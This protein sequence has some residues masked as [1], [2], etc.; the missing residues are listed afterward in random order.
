MSLGDLLVTGAMWSL[1]LA[2]AWATLICAAAAVEVVSSGRLA[3]TAWLGCPAPARR[4]LLAGLGVVLASGGAVGTSPVSAAP[5][6]GGTGNR[7]GLGLPVPVRPL[8]EAPTPE[9]RVE[10]RPGDSLWRLSAKASGKTATDQQVARL[11]TRTYR[12]NRHVIGVDPDL[13]QPGQR[14]RIPHQGHDG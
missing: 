10:V 14:L 7:P 1:A 5:P 8:G 4:A 6:V 12:A 13:I 9:R 3:V 2:G 11:V